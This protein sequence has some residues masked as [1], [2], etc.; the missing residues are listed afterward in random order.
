MRLCIGRYVL[1][2]VC[3]VVK[4]LRHERLWRRYTYMRS[5]ECHSSSYWTLMLFTYLLTYLLTYLPVYRAVGGRW[6]HTVGESCYFG[7]QHEDHDDGLRQQ[8]GVHRRPAEARPGF[9]RPRSRSRYVSLPY[10]PRHR[11]FSTTP[12]SPRNYYAPPLG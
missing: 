9:R 3:L 2:G 8:T 7:R 4:I 6:Q 11:L 5:T 1:H 10:N 12:A